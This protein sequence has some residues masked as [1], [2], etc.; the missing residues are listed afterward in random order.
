MRNNKREES[1]L[2]LLFVFFLFE[3]I[4]DLS[5]NSLIDI[6]FLFPSSYFVLS[7]TQDICHQSKSSNHEIKVIFIFL[8]QFSHLLHY[9]ACF[10][11]AVLIN[12]IFVIPKIILTRLKWIIDCVICFSIFL[13]LS[14]NKINPFIAIFYFTYVIAPT[15]LICVINLWNV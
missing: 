10:M 11:C 3:A 7:N 14:V 15:K 5:F 13:F 8:S 4:I 2:G 12:I 1:Q 9:K 6:L